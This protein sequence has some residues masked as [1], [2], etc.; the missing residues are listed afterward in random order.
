MNVL[1][2]T[3]EEMRVFATLSAALRSGWDVE[4][5]MLTFVDT[6]QKQMM[7]LELLRVHDP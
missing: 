5:E 4:Q 1:Y 3:S 6:P 2:L 7:R